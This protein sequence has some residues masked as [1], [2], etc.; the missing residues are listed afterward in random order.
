[1]LSALLVVGCIAVAARGVVARFAVVLEPP[2]PPG[3]VG[4][5]WDGA[6]SWEGVVAV[7]SVLLVSISPCPG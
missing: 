6:V 7:R 1:M 3:V 5:G 4:L 2:L